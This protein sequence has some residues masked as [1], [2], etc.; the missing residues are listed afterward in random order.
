[1]LRKCLWLWTT[2]TAGSIQPPAR[3]STSSPTVYGTKT[4]LTMTND[5]QQCPYC[6]P[7]K[8]IL[9]Q[10]QDQEAA[11]CVAGNRLRR[12][13]ADILKGILG[14]NSITSLDISLLSDGSENGLST[15]QADN[16]S[17]MLTVSQTESGRAIV[18]GMTV[19][20]Q[21][22]VFSC[23]TVRDNSPVTAF[24]AELTPDELAD[25]AQTLTEHCR[26]GRYAVTADGSSGKLTKKD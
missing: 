17:F 10:L 9:E 8:D 3:T 19:R 15:M 21:R 26:C 1:M 12:M 25:I 18:K 24:D 6:E 23:R 13:A 20:E 11:F 22:L 14:S 5:T 16:N 7:Q 4:N 2:W